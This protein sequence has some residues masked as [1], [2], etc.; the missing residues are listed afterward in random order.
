MHTLTDGGGSDEG[1][2]RG[3]R[4][5]LPGNPDQALPLEK[6]SSRNVNGNHQK[7]YRSPD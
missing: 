3:G 4:N 6:V 5:L 2:S 1:A 7:T